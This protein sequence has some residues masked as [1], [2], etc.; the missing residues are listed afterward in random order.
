M[1]ITYFPKLTDTKTHKHLPLKTIL[2]GIKSPRPD[3]SVKQI[4]EQIR[5][6]PDKEAREELKKTLPLVTF[7]GKFTERRASALVEYSN[8]ICLDFDEIECLEDMKT[9]LAANPYILACW[10]SP[11]GCGLKALVKVSSSN[12]LGHALALLKD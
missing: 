10:V 3:G 5:T 1:T 9:E 6:T 11:N 2:D 4:I 7:G 8:I 12:H